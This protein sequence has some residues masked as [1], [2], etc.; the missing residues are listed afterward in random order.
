MLRRALIPA[1]LALTACNNTSDPSSLFGE[2][3]PGTVDTADTGEPVDTDTDT[4]P[5]PSAWVEHCS[6]IT[7][8][9]VWSSSSGP[10]LVT[11]DL[12]VHSGTLTI[13]AG[14]TV[15]FLEDAAIAVGTE[16]TSAGLEAL[17]T[18]DAPVVFRPSAAPR[19]GHW[20]GLSFQANAS[21]A[22]LQ[23]TEVLFAGD[24]EDGGAVDVTDTTLTA[25]HLTI[26]DSATVGLWLH[27]S[28]Q[29][30][31][32]SDT[33][34]FRRTGTFPIRVGVSWADT[35]PDS[36]SFE[37]VGS[38]AISLHAK[39][40]AVTR[41]LTLSP[42][43]L[44]W[45]V[46]SAISVNGTVSAPLELTIAAGNTLLF[47][48]RTSLQVAQAEGASSLLLTGTSTNPITLAAL[49][50]GSALRWGGVM[51][52][53]TTLDDGLVLQHVNISGAGGRFSTGNSDL[54]AALKV[55][56]TPVLAQSVHIDNTQG[57]GIWLEGTATFAD[58]STDLSASGGDHPIELSLTEVH[59]LPA[60]ADWTG[61]IID[62]IRVDN[63][64][65]LDTVVT[66]SNPGVPLYI[67]D[68]IGIDGTAGEAGLTIQEGT[69]LRMAAGASIFVEGWRAHLR[70]EGTASAP[71]TISGHDA[72]VAGSWHR[73]LARSCADATEPRDQVVL[74]HAD[75]GWGGSDGSSGMVATTNACRVSLANTTLHDSKGYG[76]S[77]DF[78]EGDSVV[79][80]NNALGPYPEGN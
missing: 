28:A 74:S 55:V 20:F 61:N 57:T 1:L 62:E 21:T 53:R 24:G 29:L 78:T 37:D 32:S 11:C 66:W 46:Q 22:V 39:N 30:S 23:H 73:I 5:V 70:L 26:E 65:E 17:G 76:I 47:E 80:S 36:L 4:D 42:R 44:P 51:A 69:Q 7:S 41:S 38:E 2:W 77:G 79:Y 58:G 50:P 3:E 60:D 68:E 72:E 59:T 14:T 71:V 13:E 67:L 54:N 43:E 27:G 10:H 34:S 52:G 25:D 48:P 6:P 8:D 63:D 64:S 33:L 75:L 49:E 56:D 16:D 31:E 12:E 9:Q 40:A 19:P 35:L 18:S 15:Y 45:A